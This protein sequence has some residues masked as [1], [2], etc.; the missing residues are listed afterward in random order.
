MVVFAVLIV[1]AALLHTGFLVLLPRPPLMVPDSATYLE[2]WPIRTVGYPAFLS[3]MGLVDPDHRS[4]PFVQVAA[5]AVA[6][7]AM[8]ATVNRFSPRPWLWILCGTAILANPYLWRYSQSIM[9]ESFYVSLSMFAFAALTC[10]I[11][12]RPGGL[13]WLATGGLLLG[14]AILVRPVGYALLGALL[15]LL[16]AWGRRLPAAAT[17]ALAPLFACLLL[18][19]A[20]NLHKAGV[21]ATQAFG[22]ISILAQVAYLIEPGHVTG[23]YAP[24]ADELSRELAPVRE[25]LSDPATGWREHY[26]LFAEGYNPALWHWAAPLLTRTV[27]PSGTAGDAAYAPLNRAAWDI[28][29]Q[30]I[31][32]APARFLRHAA[33]QFYALWTLPVVTD[34]A[35]AERLGGLR[36]APD[37]APVLCAEYQT[38]L[39]ARVVPWPIAWLKDVGFSVLLVASLLV[40]LAALIDRMRHPLLLLVA[41]AALFV[42]ANHALVAL[43]EPGLPRYAM[44]T[45]PFL[46]LFGAGL[47]ALVLDR[48]RPPTGARTDR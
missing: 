29:G 39:P 4:L 45:W 3:L 37:V 15:V 41:G 19:S 16:L 32:G 31:L 36:C 34:Q 33:I 20:W 21:F 9:A 28:A 44:A 1:V 30:T 6:V 46:M 17:A 26:W 40:I 13:A 48:W 7:A 27:D 38:E 14:L 42:N 24:V 23:R 43:F 10:A 11:P 18:A 12:R 47:V 22:G 2:W 8:M 5:F 25:R 35:T